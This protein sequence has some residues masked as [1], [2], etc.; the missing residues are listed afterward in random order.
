MDLSICTSDIISIIALILSVVGGIFSLF[1]WRNNN[2]L[3]RAEFIR[4]LTEKVRTDDDI[5]EVMHIIDYND[6]VW[7][8][9]DFHNSDFEYKID[10]TLA[11]FSYVCYL[12][13]FKIISEKEMLPLHYDITRIL[14]NGQVKKYLHFLNHFSNSN[15]S[16]IAFIYLLNYGKKRKLLDKDI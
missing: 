15:N 8:N 13:E 11:F 2:R 9:D 4:E 5:K 12:Y 14:K 10:K 3:K 16:N 6:K 7:Y 1:Q